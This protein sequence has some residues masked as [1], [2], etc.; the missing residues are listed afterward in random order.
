[1][2]WILLLTG[3]LVIIAALTEAKGKVAI[4]AMVATIFLGAA[5]MVAAIYLRSL[6]L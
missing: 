6:G 3:L 2:T 1:M 5:M 4:V